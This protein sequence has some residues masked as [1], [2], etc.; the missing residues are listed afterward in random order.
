MPAQRR[1]SSKMDKAK[2]A[3]TDKGI[4]VQRITRTALDEAMVFVESKADLAK[5][6]GIFGAERFMRMGWRCAIISIG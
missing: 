3:L 1:T 6:K 5:I 2:K 4:K